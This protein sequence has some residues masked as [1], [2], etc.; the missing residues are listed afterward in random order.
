MNSNDNK[1]SLLGGGIDRFFQNK[2][3]IEQ[4]KSIETV[5]LSNGDKLLDINV[6]TIIANKYQP[7]TVF[8]DDALLELSK[9]IQ[10][11]G[12]LQPLIVIVNKEG[13][14]ELI[15]GERRL[16]ASRLAG[17]E[18]VPCV[19]K[20]DIKDEKRS[21]LAI[22]ENLQ[23]EDLGCIELATSYKKAM[24]DFNLSQ[25]QLAVKLGVPRT[26]VTN[27]IRLLSLPDKVIKFLENGQLSLGQG[28]I[29]AGVKDESLCI[30]LAEK[31]V[32]E[33]LTVSKLNAL[34]KKN[35]ATPKTETKTS[36]VV[37]IRDNKYEKFKSSLIE[38]TGLS[39]EIHD[40]K[41]TDG[42]KIIL[43]FANEEDLENIIKSLSR[44]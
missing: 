30:E 42:G 14:Y 17:L 28:K 26:N 40:K 34:I 5:S 25:E 19:V 21:I 2:E 23:R 31:V 22:I 3:D 27:T 43:S 33:G 11:N 7:R 4:S 18:K 8:D 37:D 10:E 13:K 9:S 35:D 16:R 20:A 6:D 32:S 36:S 15:A 29:L 1:K 39:F 41:D 44:K 12:V 24:A 38:S